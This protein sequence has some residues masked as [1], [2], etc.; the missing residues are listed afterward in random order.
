MADSSSDQHEDEP[1]VEGV[2]ARSS[3]LVA[4]QLLESAVGIFGEM[5]Y[6][7]AR[8]SDVARRCCLSSGTVY[9]RWPTKEDLFCA[10]VEFISPKRFVLSVANSDISPSDKI[11]A[12]GEFLLAH[13]NA[14]H[15]ALML[16][17]RIIA[18]R[19]AE[20]R[21][22]LSAVFHEEAEALAQIVTEGMAGGEVE[23]E[24]DPTVVA[25][26]RQA[27][28]LG[29][30]LAMSTSPEDYAMLKE[31]QWNEFLRRMIG[32]VRPT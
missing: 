6:E 12:L 24:L 28:D 29:T 30:L 16:E 32:S 15:R 22:R 13:E 20:L 17:A 7:K 27:L 1:P 18:R 25:L 11:A 23:E 26:F 2:R 14:S 31:K 19:N 21:Q 4:E 3:R 9:S 10:T 5:G 8:I